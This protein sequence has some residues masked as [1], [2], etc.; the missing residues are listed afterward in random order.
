MLPGYKQVVNNKYTQI[1]YPASC[2]LINRR[3]YKSFFT[4]HLHIFAE[5][6]DTFKL[7]T[8]DAV[9]KGL[10]GPRMTQQITKIHYE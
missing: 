10:G 1:T 7:C 8:S 2:I 4:A 5:V 9:M 3:T 6:K